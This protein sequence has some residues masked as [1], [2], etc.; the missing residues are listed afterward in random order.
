M[1]RVV[2]VCPGRGA[3]GP[4]SLG[5]LPRDHPW[6]EAADELRGGLGLPS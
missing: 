1:T 3:Y 2:V 6:L 4:A 5:S